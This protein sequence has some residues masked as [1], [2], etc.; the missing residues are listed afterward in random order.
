MGATFGA[1]DR[2]AVEAFIDVASLLFPCLSWEEAR[3]DTGQEFIV[4]SQS[5]ECPYGEACYTL[6][7]APAQLAGVSLDTWVVVAHHRKGNVM[8]GGS[9]PAEALRNAAREVARCL[10]V[11]GRVAVGATWGVPEGTLEEV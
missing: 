3:L 8:A 5:P 6:E 11:A 10:A 1:Q 9:S 7:P 4:I 2:S